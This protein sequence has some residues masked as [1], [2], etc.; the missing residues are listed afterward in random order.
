MK[1]LFCIAVSL[2][3]YTQAISQS[4]AIRLGMCRAECASVHLSG[5]P[6]TGSLDHHCVLTPG[7]SECWHTCYSLTTRPQ[8]F[9]Q[10]CL[11]SGNEC[12]E[13]C[14]TSCEHMSEFKDQVQEQSIDI[15]A[16]IVMINTSYVTVG[17]ELG[18]SNKNTVKDAVVYLLLVRKRSNRKWKLHSSSLDKQLYVLGECRGIQLKVIAVE[19][20]GILGRHTIVHGML[21]TTGTKKLRRNQQ[22]KNKATPADRGQVKQNT[23]PAG[24]RIFYESTPL[25]GF[26]S[27][28]LVSE[29]ES[30]VKY[31]VV[32]R[33][34]SSLLLFITS[35]ITLLTSVSCVIVIGIKLTR[36]KGNGK[37]VQ[38]LQKDRV[39]LE[40]LD[41][42]ERYDISNIPSPILQLKNESADAD[43]DNA[44]ICL[45]QSTSASDTTT[46]SVSEEAR[47]KSK[48]YVY[49]DSA[50]TATHAVTVKNMFFL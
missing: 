39:S 20:Q 24:S 37:N 26:L 25:S 49:V 50:A 18:E 34:P 15:K 19:K 10:H 36:R 44:S 28:S 43:L 1:L 35:V 30:T 8:T 38:Q 5:Q 47:D 3:S 45:Q 21:Q 40:F 2:L 11:D 27:T 32:S 23:T 7:C 41:T 14:H 48:L 6:V 9:Q 29:S 46:E 12:T 4:K 16:S 33:N 31:P 17:V 13:G 42:L 22:V